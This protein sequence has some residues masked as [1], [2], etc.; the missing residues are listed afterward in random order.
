MVQEAHT[1][2][3][4]AFG[5]NG[6]VRL[7]RENHKTEF[8]ASSDGSAHARDNFSKNASLAHLEAVNPS[9]PLAGGGYA[10]IDSALA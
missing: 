3:P 4:S 1:A 8:I 2:I 9:E 5:T 10:V 6:T 7:S